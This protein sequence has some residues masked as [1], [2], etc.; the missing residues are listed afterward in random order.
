[1]SCSHCH[2]PLAEGARFCPAC[3]KPTTPTET[4]SQ[5][6]ASTDGGGEVEM[7]GREI[8]GR[9]RILKKLGE[10]GMGAVYRA[11][12]IALKRPCAVKLLRPELSANQMILKRFNAEAVLVAQLGHP[13][14]VQIYDFGQDQDGA[15]FIA[16]ELI[17]GQSLRQVLQE[18][19]PL[20][21]ARAL[22]IA[23]QVA[24]S[25]TDAHIHGI[26]HRDLKPDNVMLQTRGR[27]RDI[28]RVLDFGIA[29]LRTD[30]RA[31]QP[32][33]TQAGDMLGTPQYMAPEQ[34]KGELIDGRT[35][36]YALGCMLYEMITG[37]MPFEAPTVMA[38]LSKHLLEIP[39]APSCR[40]PDLALPPALDQLVGAAMSKDPNGRPP[41]MVQFGEH[42]VE[43]LAMLTPDPDRPATRP[44]SA[45]R[46]VASPP[47]IT[48]MAASVYAPAMPVSSA[49]TPIPSGAS[50]VPGGAKALP[51]QA[52]AMRRKGGRGVLY[53]VLGLIVIGGGIGIVA[54]MG[55]AH[56]S[57]ATDRV[58]PGEAPPAETPPGEV[59]AAEN[60]PREAPVELP[61]AEDQWKAT[62]EPSLKVPEG[63]PVD[64]GQGV[65]FIVAP[66]FQ[67]QEVSGGVIATSARG[68]MVEVGPITSTT[69]DLH[70]AA[71]EYA[72]STKL[73]LD[74]YTVASINGVPRPTAVLHGLVNGVS[75]AQI[76]VAFVGT[77]YRTVVVLQLPLAL[78]ED[79]ATLAW[80]DDVLMHR[81]RLP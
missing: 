70:Q 52:S 8:V 45:M 7:I 41:G 24:A 9:Y 38:M 44:M 43:L 50:P 5:A 29:K 75:V 67:H 23:I 63:T 77:S 21:P 76:M 42:L 72:I 54:A 40:R 6:P 56:S 15:L 26:I 80:G 14:T 73:T 81:I 58:A 12:Q 20:P 46:P 39:V 60:P 57:N 2:V 78:L 37:R 11:E 61:P 33:M 35:D 47:P 64:V 30:S 27:Q 18:Q 66:D 68:L 65:T 74:K 4:Q 55:A 34:I 71:R 62:D 51:V 36:I 69:A 31:S 32:A 48:P 1:M 3:G 16:M 25:L 19:G 17:E 79:K 53:A 13:N 28:V 59:P 10:G 49:A 22:A